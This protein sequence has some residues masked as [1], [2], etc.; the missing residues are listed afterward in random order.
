MN[1]AI[2]AIKDTIQSGKVDF[3]GSWLVGDRQ[4]SLLF[5]AYIKQPEELEK[6]FKDLVQA[7]GKDPSFP[8]S[9]F[10]MVKDGDLRFHT[11]TSQVPADDKVNRAIGKELKGA[12]GFGPQ[13]VYFAVSTQDPLPALKK[14][15]AD[16]KAA[17]TKKVSPGVVDVAL[18]PILDFVSVLSPDDDTVAA[19]LAEVA[20]TPGKDHIHFEIRPQTNG[21]SFRL[22]LQEGALK[23]LGLGAKL[24]IMKQQNDSQ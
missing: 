14:A 13:S 9:K 18:Q 17:A 3:G 21:V 11:W 22:G 24:Q 4:F 7:A 1:E 15:I 6:A 16:S 20:K 23:V 12:V 19:L 2:E 10:D 5:G 8:A